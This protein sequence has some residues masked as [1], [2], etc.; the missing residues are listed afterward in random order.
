M[1]QKDK[2][3]VK[4]KNKNKNKATTEENRGSTEKAMEHCDFDKAWLQKSY[5]IIVKVYKKKKNEKKRKC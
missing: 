5:V 2:E 4:F 3:K 1:F